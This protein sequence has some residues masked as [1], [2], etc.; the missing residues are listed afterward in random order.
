CRGDEGGDGNGRQADSRRGSCLQASPGMSRYSGA[1]EGGGPGFP[2]GGDP[3]DLLRGLREFAEQQAETVQEAQREQF[4]TLTLNTAVELTAACSASSRWSTVWAADSGPG[5]SPIA[6]S[7]NASN[8]SSSSGR[9]AAPA[10]RIQP[11]IVGG[12]ST[13]SSAKRPWARCVRGFAPVFAAQ[14]AA[15]ASASGCAEPTPG[16]SSSIAAASASSAESWRGRAT[17]RLWGGV[18]RAAPT[19]FEPSSA[20]QRP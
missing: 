16:S 5:D 11:E 2:F 20:S 12:C 19:V 6:S 4:A 10:S 3:E 8:Q 1:M 13:R 9:S 17:T 7:A 18:L 14:A 15:N